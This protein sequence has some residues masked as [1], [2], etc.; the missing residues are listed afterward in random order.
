MSHTSPDIR[1]Y[2]IGKG[3]VEVMLDG[4]TVWRHVGNVVS[5]EFTPAIDKLDHFS[6]M[7]GVKSK[8]RTVVLTKSGSLKMVMEEFTAENMAMALIGAASVNSSGL[9]EIDIFS[10]EQVTC[11][12]RFTGTNEVGPK[13]QLLF[14]KV[15]FIPSAAI[16]PISDEWGQLEVTGDVSTVGGSFGTAKKLAD[17]A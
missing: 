6:S 14:N 15:D 8:D 12:V 17:E 5:F 2:Y 7:E 16:N 10:E 4:D 13:W 11:K 3:N 9:D 1:N